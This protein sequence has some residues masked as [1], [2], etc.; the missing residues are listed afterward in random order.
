MKNLITLIVLVVIK[1]KI[2]EI[3]VHLRTNLNINYA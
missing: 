3:C 1:L 2:L